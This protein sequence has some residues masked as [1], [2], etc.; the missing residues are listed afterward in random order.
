MKTH[1]RLHMLRALFKQIQLQIKQI[2]SWFCASFYMYQE[3][4][5]TNFYIYIL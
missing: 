1:L 2:W 4:C 3:D 5:Q